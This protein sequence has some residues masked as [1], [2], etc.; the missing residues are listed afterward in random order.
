MLIKVQELVTRQEPVQLQGTL[1]TKEIFRNSPEYN[2]L[3][4][5]EFDVNARAADDRILVSGQISCSVGM[6][7]SRCLDPI[8][9]KIDIPFEEQFRIVEDGNV[10]MNADDEAVPI[11]GERIDLAPF[12]A[13][14]LVVQLP[15]APLCKEDCKG[16]CPKCGTNWNEQ[17]C[18]CDTVV[19]DPRLAALQDW[20]K[21]QQE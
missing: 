18:G 7:C 1:D 17:S 3:G 20:F 2:P 13:E 4:P 12:L 21:P 15:Y 5:L 14:E 8:E 19:V 16:L 9:E 10:E 11:T 6:Q